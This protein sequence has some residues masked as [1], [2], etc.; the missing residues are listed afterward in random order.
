MQHPLAHLCLTRSVRFVAASVFVGI[1]LAPGHGQ[2]VGAVKP[3]EMQ[4]RDQWFKSSLLARRPQLPF[5]FVY[6][7]QPSAELFS[8]WPK[9][10]EIKKLDRDRTQHVLTWTDP[11]TGLETRCIVLEYADFPAVEWVLHLAN[12]GGTDTPIVEQIRPRS[13]TLAGIRCAEAGRGHGC[14]IAGAGALTIN[15]EALLIGAATSDGV[16]KRFFAGEM[17]EA[18]IWPRALTDAEL[19]TFTPARPER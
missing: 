16:P 7:G 9:K 12:T 6:G 15:S 17:E 5:S 14:E 1:M 11:K 13:R 18:A 4:Q 19:A 10:T 2:T 8:A 3:G